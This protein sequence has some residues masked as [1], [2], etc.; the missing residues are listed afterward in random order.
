MGVKTE[1]DVLVWLATTSHGADVEN[2]TYGEMAKAMKETLDELDFAIVPKHPTDEMMLVGE[3]RIIWAMP[4]TGIANC[5]KI[6]ANWVYKNMVMQFL[7]VPTKGN[8]D[9]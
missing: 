3:S 1:K 4:M 6:T 8:D 2:K 5:P 9:V 7:N